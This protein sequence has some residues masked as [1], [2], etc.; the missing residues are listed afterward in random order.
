MSI[1]H[2]IMSILKKHVY[3]QLSYKAMFF[4]TETKQRMTEYRL[5]QYIHYMS[6]H[7]NIIQLNIA[8]KI[9]SQK[10]FKIYKLMNK[11]N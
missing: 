3:R 1:I 9:T 7:S 6:T 10:G 5:I 4:N 2:L 11:L 8:E